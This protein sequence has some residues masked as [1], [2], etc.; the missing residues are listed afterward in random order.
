MNSLASQINDPRVVGP[1]Y[2]SQ[3]P[4]P[5]WTK[6]RLPGLLVGTL[7]DTAGGKTDGQLSGKC[8]DVGLGKTGSASSQSSNRLFNA[9]QTILDSLE[10][11]LDTSQGMMSCEHG[12]RKP[13]ILLV[14]LEPRHTKGH[15]QV[16]GLT[17]FLALSRP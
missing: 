6:R 8:D 7:D 17:W 10:A 16:G 15:L 12:T 1:V 9:Q 14:L 13:F 2:R 11:R 5:L 4:S 3:L